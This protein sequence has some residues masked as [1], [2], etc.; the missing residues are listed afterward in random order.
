MSVREFS[1]I[2]TNITDYGLMLQ[3]KS[4]GP[5]LK[6]ESDGRCNEKKK[7]KKTNAIA[8]AR[9][10]EWQEARA[11]EY[12][13]SSGERGKGGF[14]ELRKM[15]ALMNGSGKVIAEERGKSVN[16]AVDKEEGQISLA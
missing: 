15:E 2:L 16:R 6:E 9:D 10:C 4:F 13:R 11:A 8:N 14:E 1:L 12:Q 5:P 3:M 7:E